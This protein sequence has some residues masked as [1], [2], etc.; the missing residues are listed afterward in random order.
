MTALG[1]P[2]GIYQ[3]YKWIN[4]ESRRNITESERRT[5]ALTHRGPQAEQLGR[6][7]GG[8]SVPKRKCKLTPSAFAMSVDQFCESQG[9]DLGWHH[10]EGPPRF[11][12]FQRGPA[13]LLL[14]LAAQEAELVR[15]SRK[16]SRGVRGQLEVLKLLVSVTMAAANLSPADRGSRK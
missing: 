3:Y 4:D 8:K 2:F 7:K 1:S 13:A 10:R 6:A 14:L 11:P 12:P 5:E 16:P 9:K 15:L